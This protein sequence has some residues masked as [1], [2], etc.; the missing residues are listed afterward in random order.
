MN[1]ILNIAQLIISVLLIIAIL[2][3]SRGASLGG[4]FGGGGDVYRTQR[5]AEKFIFTT[6]I[7]L[8]VLFLGIALVNVFLGK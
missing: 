6:T 1:N 2:M 8:A 3:Q 4:V 5:G 7:I